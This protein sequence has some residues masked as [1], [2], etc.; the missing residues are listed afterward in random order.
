MSVAD[1]IKIDAQSPRIRPVAL[2][3]EHGGWSLVLEPIVLGLLLAPSPA[4]LLLSLTALGSFLARH[5]FKLAFADWRRHRHS[6]RTV[7]AKRFGLLYLFI[8]ALALALAVKAGG[9]V[10]LLPLMLAAPFVILQ[11]SYDS[12]GRSR[13]LVAELA[14][15]FSIGAVATAIALAGDWQRPA[16]FG[17]WAILAARTIPTILYLRARLRLLRRK[18]ASPRGVIIAHVLAVLVVS[19]L[20]WLSVV[21]FLSVV[22]MTIL[23]LRALLGFSGF[24]GRVTAKK[25]GLRE[26]GFGALTVLAVVTGHAVGW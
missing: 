16:A 8:A 26:L 5:P 9:I 17:L 20:A 21:P 14:G 15:S 6:A 25:L 19:G 4:G 23:L 7:M 2:P 1:Q 10:L 13:A 12:L 11:L 24:D 3:V 22:A 18:S